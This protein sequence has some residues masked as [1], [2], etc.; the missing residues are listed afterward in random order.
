[1]EVHKFLFTSF[2]SNDFSLKEDHLIFTKLAE[3]LRI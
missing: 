3:N 1:M 2:M